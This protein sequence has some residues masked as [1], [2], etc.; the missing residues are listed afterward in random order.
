V[1][2]QAIFRPSPAWTDDTVLAGIASGPQ[3]P[4]RL[5]V[6]AALAAFETADWSR[7]TPAGWACIAYVATMPMTIAYLAWFRALRL[8]P[9][10]GGRGG[11][12]SI[13]PHLGINFAVP[14]HPVFQLAVVVK[15]EARCVSVVAAHHSRVVT[16]IIF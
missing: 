14:D 2:G 9:E 10:G 5:A 12:S 7:V 6:L 11:H 13:E 15:A 4:D 1:V 8:V 3:Q 16:Q